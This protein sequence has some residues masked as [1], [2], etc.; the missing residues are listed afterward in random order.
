[1]DLDLIFIRISNLVWIFPIIRQYKNQYFYF[2]LFLSGFDILTAVF[3]HIFYITSNASYVIQ[4]LFL[5]F[6]LQGVSKFK[7]YFMYKLALLLLII[8]V[9][10]VVNNRFFEIYIIGFFQFI[11]LYYILIHFFRYNIEKQTLHLFYIVLVLF[12]ILNVLKF[13]N[14]VALNYTGYFYST[15][16]TVFQILTGLFFSFYRPDNSKLS[17]K[18]VSKR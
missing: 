16:T 3:R 14:I 11:I 9:T 13:I 12:Q 7:N 17:F 1:M 4:G 8:S 6:S 18:L 10:L 5:I 2:F 15:V